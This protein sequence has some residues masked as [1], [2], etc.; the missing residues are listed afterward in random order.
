M[1]LISQYLINT[2]G[3]C[4]TNNQISIYSIIIGVILYTSI[5]L[6]LLFYNDEYLTIFNK[7]LIYII[8]I[9]LILS[10]FYYFTLQK[11]TQT[12]PFEYIENNSEYCSDSDSD[13]EAY[14]DTDQPILPD[15]QTLEQSKPFYE[16]FKNRDLDTIIEVEEEIEQIEP[17]EPIEPTEH[18]AQIEPIEPIEPIEH[19]AQ[20]EQI[21][22]NEPIL[23]EEKMPKQS[24]KKIQKNTKP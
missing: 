11:D 20:I 14:T 13:S 21:E 18:S 23:I 24:R 3:T 12:H 5:Y 7:Y 15:E 6:Y 16:F 2:S 8:L 9:D 19:S 10:T 22:Y 17:T 1:F 4:K